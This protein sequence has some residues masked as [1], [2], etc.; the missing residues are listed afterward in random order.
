MNIGIHDI[1]RVMVDKAHQLT[2]GGTILSAAYTW[3]LADGNEYTSPCSPINA[4]KLEIKE[5]VE[6]I[7]DF[8][9]QEPT[10]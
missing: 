1:K 3:S 6:D 10:A 5:Q 2:E 8:Y 4:D 9:D 7:N